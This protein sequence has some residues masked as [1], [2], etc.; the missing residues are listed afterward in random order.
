MKYLTKHGPRIAV[1]RIAL[2]LALLHAA[3]L[4]HL[5]VLQRLDKDLS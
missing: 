4:V 2:I 1:P 3:D 5:G